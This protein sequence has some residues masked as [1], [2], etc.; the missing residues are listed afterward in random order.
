MLRK[1]RRNAGKSR[2]Y[3][4]QDLTVST[5]QSKLEWEQIDL[6]LSNLESI[7][8]NL[9]LTDVIILPEMFSTGFSMN[10]Q[11]LAEEPNGKTTLWMHAMAKKAQ[12][13]LMGSIICKDSS[14][15]YNRLIITRPDGGILTYDKRHLFRMAKEDETYSY[16]SDRKTFNWKGWNILPLVCYDLRFPVWSR[17]KGDKNGLEYDLLIYVANWPAQRISAWDI[18]LK[19]RAIENLSYCIGVN[20]IGIDGNGI[21]YNGHTGIYDPKGNPIYFSEKEESVTTVIS[22]KELVSYRNKFPANMDSD[23]FEIK[24][25]DQF[26]NKLNF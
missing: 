7:I 26:V 15:Y 16:G 3:F 18:L 17:N 24:Q 13:L 6:N 12:A 10:A 25:N 21:K 2:K 8:G 5:I 1:K 14:Q 23:E 11:K 22:G 4:M 20:R 19:A 9:P